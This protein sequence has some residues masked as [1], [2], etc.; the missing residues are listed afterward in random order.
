MRENDAQRGSGAAGAAHPRNPGL[1][2]DATWVL[3][4]EVDERDVEERAASFAGRPPPVRE[5][6]L[7][8]TL[9]A[10]RCLDLTSLS[11]D[12]TGE[13]IGDLCEKA[14]RPVAAD[15][16]AALVPD[17]PA[18]RVASVCVYPAWIVVAR[19][20]LAGSGIAVCSVAA[21]FPSGRAPLPERVAEVEAARAS[22]ADEIDVVIQRAHVLRGAWRALHDEVRAFREACGDALLKVILATGELETLENVARA[23][24]V[25]MAAGADFIKTSTG[26]EAVNATLPAGLVMAEAIRAHHEHAGVAVG[27]KPAG[28]IGRAAQA[29]EWLALVHDV[30]G[31]DAMGP[32][33]F[34]FG[35]SGL[36]A[37]LERDLALQAS[38]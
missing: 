19:A 20:A 12:E 36:L 37:D 34:R 1:P 26:K 4:A 5:T 32:E 24:R 33:R 14:R 25:V 22:G 9:R 27:L 2:F 21:D 15:V 29:L 38:P 17:A 30:L 10:I 23:S 8:W 6:R 16:L 18:L 13:R 11:G 31:A 35:A 28:G 3:A 7:A